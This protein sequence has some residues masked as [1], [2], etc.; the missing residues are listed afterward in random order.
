MSSRLK[1]CIVVLLLAFATC[2]SA[3]QWK[4]MPSSLP[5]I[6]VYVDTASV[7]VTEYVVHGWV[8][9]DYRVPREHEGKQLNEETSERMVNCQER[10]SWT[11]GGYGLPKDGSAPVRI[12]STEQYW[13][14]PAPDSQD[15]VAYLALCE[16]AKTLFDKAWENISKGMQQQQ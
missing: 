6:L 1:Y 14:A 3:A 12:Y 2:A 10:T 8:K 11:L 5:N 9:F 15:E 13:T 4:D 16:Y 7:K